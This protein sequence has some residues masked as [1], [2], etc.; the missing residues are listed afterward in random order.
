M[1]VKNAYPDHIGVMTLDTNVDHTRW[2]CISH[3][4]SM[5]CEQA[6]RAARTRGLRSLVPAPPNVR[7]FPAPQRE[8]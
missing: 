3:P 1:D 4:A 6:Q 8:I 5:T 7:P 2:P